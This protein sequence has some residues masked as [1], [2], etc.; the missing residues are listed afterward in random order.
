MKE[1]R[2]FLYILAGCVLAVIIWAYVYYFPVQQKIIRTRAETSLYRA[3]VKSSSEFEKKIPALEERIHKLR[4]ELTSAQK[5]ILDASSID[6]L[7]EKL[8]SNL[9]TFDI[10]IHAVNPVLSGSP[11]TGNKAVNNDFQNLY[12][13]V[14]MEASF[15]NLTK[16]LDSIKELPFFVNPKGITIAHKDRTTNILLINFIAEI[17]VKPGENV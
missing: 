1:K 14:S 13:E 10:K 3:K 15:K 17:Y 8:R 9:E 4:H 7:V 6:N 11:A 2:R 5:K 12:I 16:F